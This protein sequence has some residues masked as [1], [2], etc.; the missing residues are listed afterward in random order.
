MLLAPH[1]AVAWLVIAGLGAGASMVTSLSLFSL[2]AGDPRQAA[3]LS[4]MAQCVG[5]GV[6]AP[7]PLIFGMLHD[8]FASW[9]LPLLMLLGMSL[10]QMIIAPLAG[11]NKVIG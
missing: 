7:G 11:R 9:S 3:Q 6:A 5:Y 10:L 1:L 4:G 2:R 8:K